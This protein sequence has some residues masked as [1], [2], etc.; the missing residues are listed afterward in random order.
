MFSQ[1]QETHPQSTGNRVNA[2]DH[3]LAAPQK[4]T[5][6]ESHADQPSRDAVCCSPGCQ[7]PGCSRLRSIVQDLVTEICTRDPLISGA[8][9]SSE[10]LPPKLVSRSNYTVYETA[11]VQSSLYSLSTVSPSVSIL[12]SHIRY[13]QRRKK[14]IQEMRWSG[15]CSDCD[16]TMPH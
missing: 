13:C 9:S 10:Y 14:S 7:G 15:R 4:S 5:A 8:T 11:M 1:L 6:W 3:A 16:G 12:T 2:L